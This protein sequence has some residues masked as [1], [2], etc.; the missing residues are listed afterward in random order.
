MA[1]INCPECN[2]E[3]SDKA[4]SCPNCGFGV[5][6]FIERQKQ[7]EIIQIESKR[8]AYQYV[9]CKKQEEKD[10]IER[11][12]KEEED[13]KN[14]IYMQAVNKFE[15]TS[16]QD[17]EEAQKM[18]STIKGWKDADTYYVNCNNRITELKEIELVRYKNNKKKVMKF[19]VLSIS[20]LLIISIFYMNV[21][22][23]K[24]NFQDAMVLLDAEKY[25]EAQK[26]F[27]NA[28]IQVDELKQYVI[29]AIKRGE[30]R[31]SEVAMQYLDSEFVS[32]DMVQNAYYE[33]AINCIENRNISSYYEYYNKIKKEDLIV[34]IQEISY[35][36]AINYLESGYYTES[37]QLFKGLNVSDFNIEAYLEQVE[38]LLEIYSYLDEGELSISQLLMIEECEYYEKLDD[39]NKGYIASMKASLQAIQGCYKGGRPYYYFINGTDIY[40]GDETVCVKIDAIYKFDTG[41]WHTGYGEEIIGM[42]DDSLKT[43]IWIYEK[44]TINSLPDT[45][46]PYY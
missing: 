28:N 43:S 12:K 24:Q 21:I 41:R 42:I 10:R 33:S 26:N 2:K 38:I 46:S 35:K 11:E 44:I 4:Q 7:I 25:T 20:C 15:C 27:E 16:S 18:F 32:S 23:P 19:C 37:Y 31:K 40:W 5:A 1:I 22:V 45:F 17:V 13:R 34:S 36:Y 8:E 30:F 14:Q 9:K 3:V 39:I 6:E 29:Q